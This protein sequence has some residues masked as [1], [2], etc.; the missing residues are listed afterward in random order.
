MPHFFSQYVMNS[1]HSELRGG[2]A[3]MLVWRSKSEAVFQSQLKQCLCTVRSFAVAQLCDL[4]LLL[5]DVVA[6]EN[7]ILLIV[8]YCSNAIC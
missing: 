5:Y 3:R 2:L 6:N 4:M 7:I 8:Y 1:Y